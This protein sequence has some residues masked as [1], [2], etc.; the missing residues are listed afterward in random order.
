M[1]TKTELSGNEWTLI[2][3]SPSR[4]LLQARGGT[5]EV[6]LGV[7]PDPTMS[8]FRVKSD[9]WADFIRIDDFSASMYAR[10]TGKSAVVYHVEA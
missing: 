5:V 9:D 4:V 6:Y 1:T 8:G 2:S 3:T 10:A 7:N